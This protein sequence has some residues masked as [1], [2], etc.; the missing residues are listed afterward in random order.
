MKHGETVKW[1]LPAEPLH[2]PPSRRFPVAF[3]GFQMLK[4]FGHLYDDSVRSEAELRFG[5]TRAGAVLLEG[6]HSYVF[7][8]PRDGSPTIL[9]ITHSSHRRVQQILGE[10]DFTNYLTDNGMNIS[11]AMPSLRGSLVETLE[12]DSGY[13]VATAYEKAP[14]GLVDWQ[15]WTPELFESWGALI[16][17]MHSLTKGYIPSDESIRRRHWHENRDWDLESSVPESK[18]EFRRYGQRI[19]DWLLSLPMDRDSYGLIHSDLHQWNML[20]HGCELWPI[21]FDNLH[22]D[23]FLSDFTTVVINVV[24]GQAYSRER[25]RYD[26]WTGGRK[27]DS[28]EFLDHFMDSFLKGYKSENTLDPVW[29][30]RLPRFLSRHYF[31]FYIDALWDPQFVHL[32]E[33]EQAAEFPWRTLRQMENEIRQDYWGRFDFG[34]F[35]GDD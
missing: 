20:H 30:Q 1:L 29:I 22:Y 5:L 34:R 8:Y 24:I 9:K 23:W 6:S 7:D 26:E 15:D 19:K 21:D 16:G 4:Q 28:A 35:V 11:R 33:E 12:A 27:M 10:L 18:I 2:F 3:C 32:S 13:F 17:R 14:G 31:T 25:G